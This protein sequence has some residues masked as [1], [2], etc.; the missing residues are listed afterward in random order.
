MI[1]LSMFVIFIIAC[2]LGGLIYVIFKIIEHIDDRWHWDEWYELVGYITGL[3]FISGIGL[4]VIGLIIYAQ[5]I[6]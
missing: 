6:R 4:S 5:F 2:M 3:I 1:L